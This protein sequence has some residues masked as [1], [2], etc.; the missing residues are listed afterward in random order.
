[1]L[2]TL[3]IIATILIV[4]SFV[5]GVFKA[6]KE[7]KDNEDRVALISLC[8]FLNRAFLV[9]VIWILYSY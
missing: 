3:A 8:I 2:L 1:M 7:N 4:T 6:A 9:T 5:T